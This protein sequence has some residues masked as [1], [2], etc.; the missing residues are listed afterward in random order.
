MKPK[1]FNYADYVALQ[2]ELA[3]VKAE[4]DAAILD[5]T[6]AQ[7]NACLVCGKFKQCE[8]WKHMES[9]CLCCGEFEWRGR[10]ER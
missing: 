6:E 7:A 9:A 5:L 4:R 10:K 3:T 8:I 1:S 2:A